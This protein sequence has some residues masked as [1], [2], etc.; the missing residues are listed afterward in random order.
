M[1][2]DDVAAALPALRAEAVSRMSESV[3]VGVWRDGTGADGR[4]TR[5]LVTARYAG[6]GRVRWVSRDVSSVDGPGG[7]VSVREP[8]LSVPFGS[9][10]LFEGDEVLVAGSTSDPVLVGCRFTIQGG[11]VAGQTTAHR[12][13]LAE[14]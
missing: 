5:V 3:S 10:R 8:V 1:L 9:P 14:V 7:P 4:P 12:Y 2:G 11:V 13:L 6:V